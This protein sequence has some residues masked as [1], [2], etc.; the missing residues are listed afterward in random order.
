MIDTVKEIVS[1]VPASVFKL[2][3]TLSIAVLLTAIIFFIVQAFTAPPE[4]DDQLIEEKSVDQNKTSYALIAIA[5]TALIAFVLGAI[6]A[7]TWHRINGE[8]ALVDWEQTLQKGYGEIKVSDGESIDSDTLNLGG[9]SADKS[10]SNEDKTDENDNTDSS[11][12]DTEYSN[13]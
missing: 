4:D 11:D 7:V 13:L 12:E 9:K 8:S 10:N 6:G 2:A 1:K 5:I 3:I